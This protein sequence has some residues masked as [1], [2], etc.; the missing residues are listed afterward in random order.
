M[1]TYYKWLK[2]ED[3]GCRFQAKTKSGRACKIPSRNDLRP[4]PAEF[5]RDGFCSVHWKLM[6][7]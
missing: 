4:G 5:E 2:W 1:E 3:A 6:N 7:E